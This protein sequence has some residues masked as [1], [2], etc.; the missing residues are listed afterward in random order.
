[1]LKFLR[2]LFCRTCPYCAGPEE[3][4]TRCIQRD[5]HDMLRR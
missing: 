4:C 5:A 2:Y 1:M 3:P